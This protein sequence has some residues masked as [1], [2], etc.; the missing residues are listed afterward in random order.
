[1]LDLGEMMVSEMINA[2]CLVNLE[3]RMRIPALL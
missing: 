1:M 2:F 3:L